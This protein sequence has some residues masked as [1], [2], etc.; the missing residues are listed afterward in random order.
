[1]VYIGEE[2]TEEGTCGSLLTFCYV[3]AGF[4]VGFLVGWFSHTGFIRY[5]L[6]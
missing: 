3:V 2:F 4:L 6:G 1:M 5:G